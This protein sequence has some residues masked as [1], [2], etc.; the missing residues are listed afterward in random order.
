MNEC[1]GVV[2]AGE[3]GPKDETPLH[4]GGHLGTEVGDVF[5]EVVNA[6]GLLVDVG[7]VGTTGNGSEGCQVA[8]VATHRFDY[9]DAALASCGTLLNLVNGLGKEEEKPFVITYP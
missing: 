5:A 4:V 6:K 1:G 7:G 8:A 9:K 3:F 2:L